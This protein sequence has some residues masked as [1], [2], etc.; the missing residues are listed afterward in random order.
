MAFFKKKTQATETNKH[1][2][3]VKI[4][5]LTIFL[6]LVILLAYAWQNY[7]FY[8]YGKWIA[9][10]QMNQLAFSWD[11]LAEGRWW[12]FITSVFLHGG[13]DHLVLNLIA[14]LFFGK[15][16]ED[17]LGWK[18]TLLIFLAGAFAGNLAVLASMLL[19][20]M[21]ADSVTIG[22]SGAIFTLLGVAMFADPLEIVIY[23]FL[24]PVPLILVAVLYTIYNVGA[25]ISGIFTGA[26]S[27]I[28]YAAH[29]GG[30]IS[31]I[32]IGLKIEGKKKGFIMLLAILA[33]LIL[34]PI[35]WNIILYL[36]SYN[37]INVFSEMFG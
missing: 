34:I 5:Y 16:V 3:K 22:A 35:F 9:R 26:E 20:L 13:P 19:G 23:P 32:L 28:A 15:A 17:A 24:I 14:L 36:E 8:S 18:K 31:G 33:L 2:F 25:F 37:Y 6:M 4:P 21:P 12:V 30:L 10:D 7:Y 27:S 1:K 29:I 11:N